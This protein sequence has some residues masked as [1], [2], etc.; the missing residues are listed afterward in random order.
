MQSH[1]LAKSWL[2]L[3]WPG[4]LLRAGWWL[5]LLSATGCH[6]AVRPDAK[7]I[8]AL[9]IGGSGRD[10]PAGSPPELVLPRLRPDGTTHVVLAGETL[11]RI[12]RAYGVSADELA[13]VNHLDDPQKLSAGT[14][15]L[16]PGSKQPV[17]LPEPSFDGALL[18]P[19]PVHG[20]AHAA[21]CTGARCLAWPLRGV[22]YARFG[23]R[24]GENHDGLDLAAPEGT[25]IAAAADGTVLYAG[26]LSGYGTLV[27]VQHA[28][29]MVTLY[30]H[31]RENLVKEG[32]HVTQGQ[33]IARVGTSG[34]TNGPHVHFEVRRQDTPIDPLPL[35]PSPARRLAA[36]PETSAEKSSEDWNRKG[37]SAHR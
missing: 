13:Q 36:K 4:W 12:A 20:P 19:D 15:L 29:G 8:S 7:P 25:P 33:V 24:A 22:I 6:H 28:D 26:E 32:T 2:R 3:A 16:I 9:Y 17:P 23:P 14:K 34:R 10:V 35:L 18:Q 5:G 27:I 37:L 1:E 31:N 11:F 30:A 21:G